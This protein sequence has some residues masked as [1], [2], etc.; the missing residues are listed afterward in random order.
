M[1]VFIK[2][3][4]KVFIRDKVAFFLSLLSVIIL[5]ILYKIFLAQL[6]ID[7]IKEAM[8]VKSA[9]SD[10]IKLVNIWLNAGLITITCMTSTLGAYGVSVEDREYA[11]TD[12]F[13]ITTLGETK[14]EISYM[15]SAIVIGFFITLILYILGTVILIGGDGLLIG[16]IPTIQVM[17]L[18]LIGC[19]LSLTLIYPFMCFIKTTTQFA[20][21][22]TII[23]TA[24][25]FL[26][27]VYISIGSL[28]KSVGNLVTWFP[29][30]QISAILK[31]TL[32]SSTLKE[33]FHNAPKS[34]RLSYEY[35]YG[36]ILRFPDNTDITNMQIWLYIL[37]IFL[38][39]IVLDIIITH[40]V[41][42]HG[43]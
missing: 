9:P 42:K 36:V 30:T 27:G 19:T 8:N 12:D 37:M 29:L 14:L 43:N 6:Q 3:N 11:R 38:I 13:K 18:I 33:V 16:I 1:F 10:V 35:D 2:R 15:I 26:T 23:G 20:T 4:M 25:G 7:G 21:F 22:S 41:N 17:F 32:M 31:Q 40:L 34:I 24:I 28:S 39:F 5:L